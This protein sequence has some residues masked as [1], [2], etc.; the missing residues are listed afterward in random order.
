[1]SFFSAT[2]AGFRPLEH[3]DLFQKMELGTKALFFQKAT[4]S[5]PISDTTATD[6]SP[7]LGWEWDVYCNW[8]LTSDLAWTVRYGAFLPGE[9]FEDRSCRQF[10]CT[11]MTF[12]F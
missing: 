6:G 3:I 1:M 5:G 2:G 11:G 8:R 4:E 10:L 7:W 9:A 12:S